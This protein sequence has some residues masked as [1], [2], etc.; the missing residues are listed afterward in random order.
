[1]LAEASKPELNKYAFNMGYGWPM[2][3]LFSEIASTAG[4]YTF[5]KEG[6]PMRTFPIKHAVAI[7]SLLEVL[8]K[9]YPKDTYLM[10]MITN[11]DL[12][13]WEGT[14]FERLGNL[15]DAFAVL[16]YTLPGMP[17]F[18]TG[19]ETGLNRALEFFKKDECPTWEPR[20][21]YFVF[22]QKLNAL[23]HSQAALKAGVEGGEMVRY[24]TA[25]NDLYVFSRS[26]EGSDVLVLV[27]LGKDAQAVEFTSEAP[28][29]EDKINYFTGE[30]EALPTTLNA[31]EY[32]VYINK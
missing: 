15:S 8:D 12:N 14:E 28:A 31:G 32:R 6:E 1:M 10:N 4:Q 5:K 29:V 24:A 9:T 27:N 25:S 16:S 3:D 22:Y 20:N 19:Q 30:A 21:E 18:Y 23:K 2:K 13:S 11:H 26:V 17:L 7:D